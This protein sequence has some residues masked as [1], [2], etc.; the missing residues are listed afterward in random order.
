MVKP[1]AGVRPSIH[2]QDQKAAFSDRKLREAF[3]RSRSGMLPL[4]LE[5]NRAA[6]LEP[7]ESL[8]ME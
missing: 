2:D 8:R 7:I 1:F 5:A 6:T 3:V 4:A